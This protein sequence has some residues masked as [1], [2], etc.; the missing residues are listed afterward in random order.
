MIDS[1][2]LA[3][4]QTAVLLVVLALGAFLPRSGKAQGSIGGLSLLGVAPQVVTGGKTP[5]ENAEAPT[6]IAVG[7]MLRSLGALESEGR[8]RLVMVGMGGVCTGCSRHAVL[9]QV[10]IAHGLE[11]RVE[12][13][14]DDLAATLATIQRM[15]ERGSLADGTELTQQQR[16]GLA[17]MQTHVSSAIAHDRFVLAHG[18][19]RVNFVDPE[20]E[21]AGGQQH[22]PYAE[23]GAEL[24]RNRYLLLSHP[25]YRTAMQELESR[26]LAGPGRRAWNAAELAALAQQ[27]I[28]PARDSVRLGFP[29]VCGFVGHTVSRAVTV[30]GRRYALTRGWAQFSGHVYSGADD[31]DFNDP[32]LARFQG[33][34]NAIEK[35]IRDAM[36]SYQGLAAQEALDISAQGDAQP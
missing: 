4:R 26:G 5:S 23:T 14:A 11:D 19:E 30:D 27:D 35:R 10:A 24:I 6:E 22:L 3:I 1:R 33:D 34:L 17:L 21:G 7:L 16:T 13:A 25:Q 15:L 31:T 8:P 2:C 18:V 36:E 28:R 9:R 12:I 29:F 32:G 20:A